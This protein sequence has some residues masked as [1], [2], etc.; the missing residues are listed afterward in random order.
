MPRSQS[1]NIDGLLLLTFNKQSSP[2]LDAVNVAAL[3]VGFAP[4]L[5]PI[6]VSTALPIAVNY[7]K[8]SQTNHK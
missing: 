4:G 6:I 3:G 8:Q 7:A 5:A 1:R 2:Y